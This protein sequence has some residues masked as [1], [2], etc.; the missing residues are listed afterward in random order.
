MNTEKKIPHKINANFRRIRNILF[1]SIC[2]R[3]KF[4][5]SFFI[6]NNAEEKTT[7]EFHNINHS[8]F[9][10]KFDIILR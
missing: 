10:S 4:Y 8:L 2:L 5:Y 1:L 6:S 7:T 3:G 9:A